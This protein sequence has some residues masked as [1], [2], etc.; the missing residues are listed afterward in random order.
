[1]IKSFKDK[2]TEMVFH[3]EFSKKIPNVIQKIALRKLMMINV[4]EKLSDLKVPPGNHLE[5]LSG[6]KAGKWSIRINNQ[7]RIIFKPSEN[8]RDYEDVEI[9]DYH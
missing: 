1:M 8:G 9:I 2:E 7:W 4:A 5:A 3:Q 6:D